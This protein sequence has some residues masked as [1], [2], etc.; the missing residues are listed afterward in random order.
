MSVMIDKIV[1]PE[2]KA[3]Q[4]IWISVGSDKILHS[5]PSDL[6][7]EDLQTYVDD[8]EDDYKIVV[9]QYMYPK[10]DCYN[11]SLKEWDEWID[12]GC[13]N[14][15]IT[16]EVSHP[17]I[18]AKDAVYKQDVLVEGVEAQDAVYETRV[19]TPA[20][21]AR[22]AVYETRLVSEAIEAKEAVKGT[23]HKIEVNA[24]FPPKMKTIIEEVDGKYIQKEVVDDT[25]ESIPQYEEVPLYNEDGDEVGKH[26]IPVME[27]YD[28]E[29]AVEAAD[30]VYEEVLISEATEA[31]D[32]VTKE[33]LVSR[34]IEAVEEILGKEVLVSE[35]VE[36]VDSW[37]ET[38][39]VKPEEVIEK[40]PWVNTH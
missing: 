24:Y 16:K 1:K 13:K 10:A 2:G 39:I 25:L 11:G 4:N 6:D 29:P 34:A 3:Y 5:A 8:R 12:N 40:K 38:I 7:G 33:V 23:R 21:P 27:E 30:A 22:D 15:E 17:E 19:E 32:E 14:P 35:A 9:Y 36:A 20:I 26:K 31:K 28:A 37:D 18:E